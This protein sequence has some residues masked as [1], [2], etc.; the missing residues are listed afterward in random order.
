M[1]TINSSWASQMV[2]VVQNLTANA[3]VK[4][5]SRLERCGFDPWIRKVP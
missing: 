1:G 2:L 4:N 5:C 3:V